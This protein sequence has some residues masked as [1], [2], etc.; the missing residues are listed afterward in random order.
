[1]L[2]FEATRPGGVGDAYFFRMLLGSELS[3]L[4]LYRATVQRLWCPPGMCR[5]VCVMACKGL[6]A[7]SLVLPGSNC[8]TSHASEIAK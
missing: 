7:C 8:T 3:H 1:M 5:H 4:Q 2:A 6:V